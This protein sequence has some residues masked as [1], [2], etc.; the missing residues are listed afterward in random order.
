MEQAH[1]A[2][3]KKPA[4][5]KL[6]DKVYCRKCFCELV[7]HKIKH[8]LRQY[9]IKKDSRLLVKD[10]ASEYVVRKVVNLPVNIVKSGRYDRIILPYTLDDQNEA[11]L[12]RFFEKK[13]QKADSRAVRLFEPLSKDELKQYL[14]IKKVRYSPSKTDI[15][16]MLDDFEQ[17]YPGTKAS[18]LSS[19]EKL[20]RIM[21]K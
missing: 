14:A 19:E 16:S 10:R 6:V 21:R 9:S 15:N 11:M 13:R 5:Y 7:E 4:A 3:C 8:N 2:K 18:I 1:C 20:S 12:K 17:K